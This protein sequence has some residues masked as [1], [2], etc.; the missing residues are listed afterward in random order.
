ML[1][2]IIPIF[3][4]NKTKI[5]HAPLYISNI[6]YAGVIDSL[7]STNYNTKEIKDLI[8]DLKNKKKIDIMNQYKISKNRK[9][10]IDNHENSYIL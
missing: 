8:N 5:L 4:I 3:L 1:I 9:S 10:S 2:I 7:Y 6:K